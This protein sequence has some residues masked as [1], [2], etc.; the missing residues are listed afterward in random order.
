MS[1]QGPRPARFFLGAA[2][3]LRAPCE[4]A[5]GLLDLH[6]A[7]ARVDAVAAAQCKI[8]HV[9]NGVLFLVVDNGPTAA[10][11]KQAAPALLVKLQSDGHV[12]DVTRID[13]RVR[14]RVEIALPPKRAVLSGSGLSHLER[15]AG[16]LEE[17][18]LKT[19]LRALIDR[20]RR[21]R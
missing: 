7:L 20:Q 8:S 14:P 17:T 5:Q 1:G 2:T 21:R 18:P 15:Y 16:N 13:V 19:A 9:K 12:P 11:L 6:R 10:K 4:L 3:A